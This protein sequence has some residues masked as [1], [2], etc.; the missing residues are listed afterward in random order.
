M[1]LPLDETLRH[2]NDCGCCEGISGETPARVENRPGL[3]AI[4]Y[5]AGTHAQFKET[6]LAR[7]SGSRQGAL[8]A[9]TTRTDE[10]FTVSLLDAWA[11]VADVLTFYQERIANESYLRT[12]TERLSVAELAR[13][14]GYQ[15]RP[16][17]SASVQLAFTVE[18]APGALGPAANLGSSAQV[19]LETPPP[20]PVPAGVKVQ[21]IPGPGEKA[22]TYETAEAIEARPEWNAIRPRL[23][24]PQQLTTTMGSVV[25]SGAATNVQK[26][27]TLLLVTGPGAHAPRVAQAV[28][29]DSDADLTRVDFDSPGFSATAAMALPPGSVAD[30]PAGTRLD[31]V[32]IQQIV[33][34]SWSAADLSALA[35][36]QGWP[37]ASLASGINE[38]VSRRPTMPERGV[39]AFRQ[40]AAVFGYNAPVWSSLPVTMR[41]RHKKDAVL[42]SGAPDTTAPTTEPGAFATNWEGRT[43]QADANLRSLPNTVDLDNV[44]PGAVK[45]S[46]VVLSA[47]AGQP[48]VFKVNDAREI[49]RTDFA[50]SG[51]VSR[52][53]LDAQAPAFPIRGTSVLAQSEQLPTADVPVEGAVAG[54]SV[55]LGRA[56]LGLRP[57]R[58]VIITGARSD[59][60]SETVSETRTL[61]EVRV[62]AGLTVLVFDKELAYSYVRS[63]VSIN[64]NVALA[65]HGESVEEVL[66]GGDAARAFQSFTLRQPPLT[67]TS[68]ASANG[69]QS[70]LEV[71]VNDL[72]WEEVPSFYGRG[73]GERIYVT[74]T[75]TEGKTT[76]MFGDGR[77][78]ARLPTGPENVRA[79]YRKGT[80]LGGLVKAG[81]LSMLMTRPLGVKGVVNP[82]KA[83]G[84]GDPEQLEDARSNAPL[85]VLTLGRVV[86]LQD[87][88]DFARSFA[89]I[90]KALAT[91]V[92]TGQRRAVH[93][94]VAGAD[95]TEVD[96]E[97]D[98]GKKLIGALRLAGDPRVPLVFES[99]RP[100]FFI[101]SAAVKVDPAHLPEKVLAAAEA[102]LR[103]S[104]SFA[105]RSFGQS[106]NLSD[107]LA[108]L[109]GVPGVVA[110]DVN[111]FYGTD[112]P[113]APGEPRV[114]PRLAAERPRP[115]TDKTFP[116]QILMLDPR[117][118]PLE[119]MP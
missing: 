98:L 61:K 87:Y 59:L 96:P 27:D 107:V 66:G 36:V 115:G 72:L 1:S 94:T 116:A 31:D 6:M 117:P 44:Y 62:V 88:E 106:A 23:A 32:V 104:F 51:K 34:K 83:A 68:A 119:V 13:L 81:Q 86:S 99:Y 118:V 46:W 26:G 56:Y 22:Q 74:R 82:L 19:V 60:P 79:K 84:A 101:L 18:D 77:T 91:W 109:V 95:G 90:G 113:P 37:E 2:L 64:A 114:R 17:V 25:L 102:K 41:F 71:R 69:S 21:S 29:V 53:T 42:E 67:H 38:L 45:N 16:G 105:A 48:A 75:D 108:L 76:V 57:G 100:R 78:G 92:W 89:G 97:G 50:I 52:L 80:G 11:V 3:S 5:R 33:S 58:A 70:S 85:A 15:L 93:L 39:F 55:T 54:A 110:V 4:A 8:R 30:F 103:E 49:T 10:D 111:D 35:E 12:A 14:I 47:P 40:R 43:L 7:L 24:R 63:T 73:P 65:T 9:F 112:A 20:V 28:T